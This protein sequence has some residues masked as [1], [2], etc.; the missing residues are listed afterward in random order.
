MMC[1]FVW[2]PIIAQGEHMRV[3]VKR[4]LSV[5]LGAILVYLFVQSFTALQPV[6]TPASERVMPSVHETT[7]TQP[8]PPKT[9]RTRA[10]HTAHSRVH[11]GPCVD[12][13]KAPFQVG[14]IRVCLICI[15]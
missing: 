6:H 14:C 5:V 3:R 11:T 4:M 2:Q 12:E 7:T 8:V 10:Q 1:L 13:T 9:T 15:D